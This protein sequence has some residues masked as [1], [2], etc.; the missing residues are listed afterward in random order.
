LEL[1]ITRNPKNQQQRGENQMS[2]EETKRLIENE[3]KDLGL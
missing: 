1:K 3:M 2:R